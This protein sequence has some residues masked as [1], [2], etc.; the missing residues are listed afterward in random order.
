MK[1]FNNKTN[2]ALA[3]MLLIITL[4]L[5]NCK[6]KTNPPN[7]N[8]EE[9]ITTLQIT[10]QDS[11]GVHPDVIARYRDIDGDGGAAPS[12]WDSIRLKSNTTYFA[13]ILLL[14]ESASPADTISNEVLDEANDH[15][16]CFTVSSINCNITRTDTDGNGLE[17]GLQSKWETG[18]SGT[19]NV[20]IQLRHQPDSKT[21]SCNVGSSDIDLLFVLQNQ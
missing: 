18:A 10:F 8:E 14:D 5:S 1:T 6:K 19:G 17:I 16:F 13:S 7:P 4:G 11:A 9:L 15:L 12:I 21:G 20:Q 3:V 2:I